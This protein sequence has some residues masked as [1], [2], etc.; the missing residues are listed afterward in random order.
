[1]PTPMNAEAEPTG[2]YTLETQEPPKRN[3][4][5]AGED[6]EQ[7]GNG[8]RGAQTGERQIL[9]RIDRLLVSHF[10][11]C[12]TGRHCHIVILARVRTVQRGRRL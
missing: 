7:A 4:K 9:D 3:R 12:S 1:M 11:R 8:E 10:G 2:L 5:Q 6:E